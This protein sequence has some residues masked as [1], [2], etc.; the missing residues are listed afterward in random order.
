LCFGVLTSGEHAD[1]SGSSNGAHPCPC[2]KAPTPAPNIS[3]VA[4]AS[5]IGTA[6][7]P[8]TF[9]TA[10]VRD[11][12]PAFQTE[13]AKAIFWD[14]F[15][16]YTTLHGYV[17]W[18]TT[19]LDNHYHTLGYL[20]IGNELGEMMRKLHGSV[21]WLVMKETQVRHVP[22]WRGH[23]ARDYFDG[24]I[25]SATQ[26]RRAYGY[27][28]RQAVRAGIVRQWQDYAHTRPNVDCERA[29]Q[30]AVELKAFLEG[31]PYARYE[32]KTHSAPGR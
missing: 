19:V 22:F 5:S 23:G 25:R 31:V 18:V 2:A 28:L 7:T 20:R 26:A 27:T 6:T 32:R 9:I 8:S 13:N 17:P 21:A 14:R 12:F 11:G 29:I 16:Y 10:K 24:Y 15:T 3:R 4:T 1:R 30:R